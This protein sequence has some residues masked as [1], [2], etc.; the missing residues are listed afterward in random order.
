MAYKLL[1]SACMLLCSGLFGLEARAQDRTFTGFIYET[2]TQEAL[3]GATLQL[4]DGD[5]R[6]VV[7]NAKGYFEIT[8][9]YTSDA[10]VSV[11]FLGY[12]EKA[13]T[14]QPAKDNMIYLDPSDETLNTVEIRGEK[15]REEGTRSLSVSSV[16]RELIERNRTASLG[17]VLS[18]VQGVT[19]AS[20]GSNIQLPVIHG[21][22]GNRILILNNGFKHGFQNWG[23][24]HAPEIDINSAES[25]SVI[26]GAAAV[27]YGPDALG[28]AVLT[29]SNTLPFNQEISGQVVTGYQTNGRGFNT[30]FDISEGKERFSWHAGGKVNIVG[31]REAPDYVLT[32]TGARE[33]TAHAGARYKITDRLN[34][35]AYY[36]FVNQNL[37]ILRASIGSSGAALIRNFEAERPTFIRDFSYEINEPNQFVRHHLASLKLDYTLNES[38]FFSLR[39]AFQSN[40]REEFDVRRNADLP[41]ID[42]NLVSN[43]IQADWTHRLA[44]NWSGVAGVQILTQQNSNNPGT[45]ITPFIPNY[46]SFRASAFLIETYT[47]GNSEWEF[48]LRYDFEQNSVA[49]R[50]RTQAQFADNFTFSNFTAA[51]GFVRELSPRSTFRSNLGTGWRPPNMAELYSFGQHEA[52]Q[53]FGLLR[54]FEDEEGRLQNNRVV[55]FNE[56]GVEAEQ[57]YKWMNEIDVKGEKF[58]FS[59]SA[60]ANYIGNFIYW[61]PIGVVGTLRGPMPTYIFTQADAFFT[62]ADVQVEWQHTS[63]WSSKFGGSYIWSWNVERDEPLINQP[64]IHINYEL[65]Y[66]NT[67]VGPFDRV[68]FSLQPSYTFRQFQAPREVSIRSL[69]EGTEVI[70]IDSEIFDFLAPP[71]G[72][73]LLNAFASAEK[74]RI[75]GSVMVT[76]A[77]NT[78][79]R[80]YLN[81]MRFFADDLGRNIILSI[82]YKF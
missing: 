79:Y 4:L 6:I 22:Y 71:P 20:F 12:A 42:L 27:R 28:G 25:I 60:Y 10:R 66:K 62:G 19:F 65:N 18:G 51:L 77:L 45:S 7:A 40:Q 23:S 78:R 1:I 29:E 81:A 56:S 37:G 21:L 68:E 82:H 80:D 54:Y 63:N 47:K 13:V 35:R 73:F 9:P 44:A 11:R 3:A 24:D 64:P 16:D 61:R 49:G 26:K 69:I 15:M 70:S 41:I 36:S 33:F 14:L 76:N 30:A 34:A 8:V 38:N 74:G 53:T 75:G 48:G 52:R 32:N 58:R 43:D 39:Y 57:S 17:T 72:Y 31:D 50:E 59:A 55:P 2:G 46:N 67:N 5:Q